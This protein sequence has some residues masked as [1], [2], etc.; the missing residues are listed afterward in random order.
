M[1]KYIQKSYYSFIDNLVAFFNLCY[2]HSYLPFELLRGY[3]KPIINIKKIN[4]CL[5]LNCI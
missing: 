3:I 5:L 1:M 4:D 2:E